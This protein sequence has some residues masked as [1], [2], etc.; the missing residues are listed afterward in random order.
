MTG[1][2]Q[3][4]Q[5]VCLL[6]FAVSL[7]SPVFA[8]EQA[9]QVTK[10]IQQLEQENDALLRKVRRLERQTA[11]QREELSTPGASQ[12]IGGLGYIVGLF[13][14]AGWAAARKKSRQEK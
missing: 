4:S 7:S 9:P 10:S 6:L 3:I 2:R 11:A 12:I 13:G 14:V 5:C 1:F 8:T